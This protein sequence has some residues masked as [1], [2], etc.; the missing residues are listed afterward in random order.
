MPYPDNFSIR[1]FQA[2]IGDEESDWRDDQIIELAEDYLSR[3]DEANGRL[4]G[5]LDAAEAAIRQLDFPLGCH[6][7]A[8]DLDDAI[9]SIREAMPDRK[10]RT[11]QA[12]NEAKERA[13]IELEGQP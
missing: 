13:A 5:I 6:T 11:E 3:Q 8:G 2:Y 9:A 7:W 12:E 10:W 4:E 1:Q